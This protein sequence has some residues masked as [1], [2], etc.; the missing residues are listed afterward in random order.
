MRNLN[1]LPPPYLSYFDAIVNVKENPRRDR[2]IALKPT[3]RSRFQSYYQRRLQ[4]HTVAAAA[5]T[6]E[7]QADLRDCYTGDTGA[8][9]KLKYDI[10]GHQNATL[11]AVCQ[12]CGLNPAPRTFDHYLPKGAFA[13]FSMLCLNLVP[14]CSDCNQLKHEAWL[15]NGQR[16][17]VSFYYD[18]LPTTQYLFASV[19][20][21]SGVPIAEFSMSGNAA[22][23]GGLQ[24]T[25][26]NH[27]EKLNLL[28]RYK[29]AST[30]ILSEDILW[31]RP[32]VLNQGVAQVALML[33]QRADDLSTI[34]SLNFWRVALYQAMA[35]NQQFLQS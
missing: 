18:T 30:A 8:L 14:C 17:V 34:W 5:L 27:F 31:I 28:E 12:Y 1:P 22:L 21:N 13:E 19:T 10:L 33:A 3:V 16:R 20:L 11:V 35:G 7:A 24:T 15:L 4:L 9:D 23:Y 2:L 32:M 25:I 29:T 26:Q 6:D